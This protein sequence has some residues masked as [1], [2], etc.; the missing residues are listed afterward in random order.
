MAMT[1]QY[2]MSECVYQVYF[3]HRVV[4]FDDIYLDGGHDN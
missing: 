4:H 2:M 1:F 3:W